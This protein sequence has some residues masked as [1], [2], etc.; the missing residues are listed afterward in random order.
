[1]VKNFAKGLLI[2]ALAAAGAYFLF[3]YMPQVFVGELYPSPYIISTNF[4]QVRWYG[5]LIAAAILISYFWSL[6]T[7][8]KS[9]LDANKFETLIFYLVLGGLIGARIGFVVQ[10]FSYYM[11]NPQMI[12]S[13][14]TGGLSIHGALIGGILAG[15]IATRKMKINFSKYLC[16]ALPFVMF[17]G[18]IGRFGNFFNQEIIGKPTNFFAKMYV[19]AENRPTGYETSDF[20]HPVFLYE[21]LLLISFFCFY[22]FF[23]KKRFSD[24]FGIAYTLIA[25]SAAR[26][27][28]EPFRIDYKPLFAKMDLAQ[29]VSIAILILGLVFYFMEV[30]NAPRGT[31]TG[32]ISARNR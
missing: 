17:S 30:K 8:K 1:M 2:A 5:L 27:V 10:N 13:V 28:V 25:Y 11:T 16:I 29:L 15:F 21:S 31:K 9:G 7:A 6:E 12:Y 4:I 24:R 22:F 3:I 18:A 14:W 19:W 32:A 20:F 23:L 26:I